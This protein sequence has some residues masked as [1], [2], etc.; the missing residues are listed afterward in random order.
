MKT[1][2]PTEDS[3]GRCLNHGDPFG[4]FYKIFTA[5]NPKIA[6]KFKNTDMKKQK[7]LLQHGIILAN[8]FYNDNPVG[9]NGIKRI[10]ETHSQ[11]RLDINPSLYTIWLD[12]FIK[13]V[14]EF[15]PKFDEEIEKEW[16]KVLQ[17]TIDY[18]IEGYE[19]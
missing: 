7:D 2:S 14:S 12:S 19:A 10:R 11:S 3:L 17:K 18:I 6:M 4:R 16:R 15:D 1:F 13:T 8:M 9:K 5:S